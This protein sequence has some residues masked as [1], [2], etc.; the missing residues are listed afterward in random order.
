MENIE[1]NQKAV[2]MLA[3]WDP[4]K[5]GHE[6]YDTETADIVAAMQGEIDDKELAIMI[7]QVY[8]YS[9]EKLIPMDECE[10]I[11]THLLTLKLKMSCDMQ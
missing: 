8:E 4:F 10:K 11:A 5:I 9:F 6:N 2:Q 1:M 3:E 7:Q